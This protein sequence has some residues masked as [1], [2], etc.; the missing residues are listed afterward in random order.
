[1]KILVVDDE[2][3]I[4]KLI[5]DFLGKEGYDILEA[6]NGEEAL[7]VFFATKDIDLI[8]IDVMMPKLDGFQTVKEIRRYSQVPVMMLTAK[9]EERD[10]L[11]GFESGVDE[12]L[13]K[14]FSP[15]VL[16]ARVTAMLRRTQ[17]GG[18][19][20]IESSGIVIDK[21]AH[22][23]RLDGQDIDVS[24]KEY[25]LLTFFLLNKNVALSREK[26]LN[27]VWSYDFYGDER[28][29]DTHVKKLRSK[30]GKKGDCIKTVW[31]FGYKFEEGK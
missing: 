29:I 16:V 6:G 20:T 24:Q 7:D 14:P 3:R 18:E 1:M 12:Y 30:L 4:K 9:N 26:I 11:K 2:I 22:Q 8:I 23:V 21:D 27:N 31:G 10:E 15:R 13:T 28:T 5:K 19:G 25:E 17:G